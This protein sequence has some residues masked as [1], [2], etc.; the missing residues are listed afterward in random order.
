MAAAARQPA[1]RQWRL[2]RH[3]GGNQCGVTG[4]LSGENL[5]SAATGVK[6]SSAGSGGNGGVNGGG[7]NGGEMAWRLAATAAKKKTYGA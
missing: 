1:E 4:W 6:A 5:S 3:G 7:E 2:S